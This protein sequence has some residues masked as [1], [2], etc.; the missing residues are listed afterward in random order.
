MNSFARQSA[1]LGSG[2]TAVNVSELA[3]PRAPSYCAHAWRPQATLPARLATA[4]STCAG[5]VVVLS[6][7]KK[8]FTRA[9]CTS[10]HDTGGA[11]VRAIAVTALCRSEVTAM[12]AS[13]ALSAAV[14]WQH[15]LRALHH[16]LKL[17]VHRSACSH[18]A[19]AL[20]QL[21]SPTKPESR[22]LQS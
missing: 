21:Q 9:A 5:S 12:R 4:R 7:T 15:R 1:V 2:G 10:R 16:A 3:V 13:P 19:Y 14:G 18:L 20:M 22:E 17:T 8:I 11:S 6:N